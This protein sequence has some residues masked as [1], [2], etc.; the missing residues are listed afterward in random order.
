MVIGKMP[1]ARPSSDGGE[2]MVLKGGFC[3]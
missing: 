1:G 2:P 3:P